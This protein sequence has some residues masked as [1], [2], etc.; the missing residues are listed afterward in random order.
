MADEDEAGRRQDRWPAILFRALKGIAHLAGALV[1]GKVA[2]VERGVIP[3]EIDRRAA[4]PCVGSNQ[5]G[6]EHRALA[7]GVLEQPA[8][9]AVGKDA[10]DEDEDRVG[11]RVGVPE[12][13]LARLRSG[14]RGLGSCWRERHGC[15]TTD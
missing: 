10:V 15:A 2:G 12:V 8:V 5:V 11:V 3:G 9:V 14:G 7:G 4:E 13:V 6:P 1:D